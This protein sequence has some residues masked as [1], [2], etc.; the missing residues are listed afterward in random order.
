M[1]NR[2]NGSSW[3][4]SGTD[5]GYDEVVDP[6]KAVYGVRKKKI[7]GIYQTKGMACSVYVKKD[8][9]EVAHFVTWSGLTKHWNKPAQMNRFSSEHVGKYSATVDWNSTVA[10]F[11]HFSFLPASSIF[12]SLPPKKVFVIAFKPVQK[13]QLTSDFEAYCFVG[14]QKRKLKLEFQTDTKTH[15]LVTSDEDSQKL[16]WSSVLGAPIIVKNEKT[17]AHKS[18]ARW[19][20]V[21]VV[22][23]GREGELCPHFVTKKIFGE[24]RWVLIF[25][26]S[27]TQVTLTSQCACHGASD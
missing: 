16:E 3:S 2:R 4:L 11:G 7:Q 14:P 17:S 19:S 15:K 8:D 5:K 13:Q 27:K 6:F 22:G 23:L 12:R 20:V 18:G 21:G 25:S 26:G 24:F 1:A 10:T 9:K